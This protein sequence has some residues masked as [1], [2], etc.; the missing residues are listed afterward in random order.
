MA[1]ARTSPNAIQSVLC[2]YVRY[3]KY[4]KMKKKMRCTSLHQLHCQPCEMSSNAHWH[5]VH[6][7]FSTSSNTRFWD[8]GGA[9]RKWS[10]YVV[11]PRPEA[12]L[13]V[14]RKQS[15]KPQ[16]LKLASTIL[17]QLEFERP[18]MSSGQFRQSV[19]TFLIL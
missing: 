16:L 15:V 19:D 13:P 6:C 8:S 4:S 9:Q 7:E 2:R 1:M 12:T 5:A 11:R 3:Q 18:L 10:H 17:L 14:R